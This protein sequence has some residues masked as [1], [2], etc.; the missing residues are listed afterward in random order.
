[1]H[2]PFFFAFLYGILHLVASPTVLPIGVSVPP[3]F[4]PE[5]FL[6]MCLHDCLIRWQFLSV[7]RFKRLSHFPITPMVPK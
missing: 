3:A 7:K 2:G 6:L 1:M 5:L 4:P